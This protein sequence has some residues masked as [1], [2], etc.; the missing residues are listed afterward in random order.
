[1]KGRKWILCLCAVF[2]ALMIPAP[3]S[4]QT[5]KPV[6]IMNT[7]QITGLMDDSKTRPGAVM[8]IVQRAGEIAGVDLQ[9]KFYPW[10]RAMKNVQEREDTL[11]V[12]ISRTP[13][14]EKKFN[15]VAHVI[16]MKIGFVTLKEPINS[17]AEGKEASSVGFWK[18]TSYHIEL[19]KKGFTNVRPFSTNKDSDR[20]IT[21]FELGRLSSWYGDFFEF[22]YRWQKFAKNKKL[23]LV[24]GKAMYSDSIW[25]AASLKFPKKMAARLKSAMKKVKASGANRQI[26]IKY[27]GRNQ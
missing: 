25:L 15:W 20:A 6:L 27:F 9:A 3:S 22:R 17:Y 2:A 26:E 7:T 8:E 14:R 10:P 24:F 5:A 19:K 1:M 18:G 12:G 21:L 16:D 11:I 4:A 23:P 13:S